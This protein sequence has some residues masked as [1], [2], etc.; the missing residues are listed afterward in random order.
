M[1]QSNGI[2]RIK[3]ADGTYKT[4]TL[5]TTADTI[6]N[7]QGKTITQILAEDVAEKEHVH[8]YVSDVP[9]TATLG[10]IEKGFVTDGENIEEIL[11]KL[12]HP[13]V[14]PTISYT[15]S[16]NGGI[17]EI[18]TSVASINIKATGIRQSDIIQQVRIYKN[19]T[20]VKTVD[21]N[22]TGNCSVEYEDNNITAN[23][24]YK[25][26]VL[27]G[28]NTATSSTTT[29]TFV[30]PA[31]VGILPADI[32]AGITQDMIDNLSKKVINPSNISN[33]FTL[34]DSRMCIAVP[35]GW[36]IKTIMDPNGFD[37]TSSF[38][39]QTVSVVC[40]DGQNIDYTFY[41]SDVT[42]QNTFI[43][44]FNR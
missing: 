35:P 8:N 41:V 14:K 11:F 10:G 6:T 2:V 1:S 12:L 38:T 5:Q 26:D 24:N 36:V 17:Y 18:G 33:S 3:Q 23:T 22:V 32:S 43:V 37:I 28:K 15:C 4:V 20:V 39:K 30:R 16:P 42:S 19:G 9:S 29:F 31:Y 21:H 40:V 7:E 13:Y 25:A 27:D 44:K 34:T